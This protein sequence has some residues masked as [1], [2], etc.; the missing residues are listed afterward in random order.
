MLLLAITLFLL[1]SF[2]FYVGG[3]KMKFKRMFLVL[4]LALVGTIVMGCKSDDVIEIG[5]LQ[6]LEHNALTEARKGFIEGL[7]EAGFVDG[8][9]I[10]IK[11]LNP[12]TDASTMALQAK[13]LVRKSDLILAIATPAASAVVNEAKEQGKN[14]PILFTAVTDPVA[15]KLI[16]SNEKPGGFVT[17]T[18]DNN[19]IPEQIA[20]VKELLPEAKKLGIIYTASETNSEIQAGVAK[21]EAEKLGMTVE[22]KTIQSVNDLRQVANQLASNVDAIYIPT[23]NAI[24]ASMGII[25]DVISEHKIPAIVGESNMVIEGGSITIGI[26]YFQLGKDTAQM[27]IKILKDKKSPKDIP[28]TGMTNYEIVINNKQLKSIGITVSEDLLSRA[29]KVL[30]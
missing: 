30:N 13:E 22:I 20:L 27:A 15:A 1:P 10:R 18:N 6:Y 11:V 21:S 9:N 16:Q 5:I 24:A 23:D 7:E 14:T 3:K 17:G 19:P 4:M 28:S 29:D 26:N 25:G 2:K 8:E 12:E